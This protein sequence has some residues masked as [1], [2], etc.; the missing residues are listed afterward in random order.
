MKKAAFFDVDHTLCRD[1][2]AYLFLKRA[3]K[4]KL[5]PLRF[6]FYMP[7][8][9]FKYR[10]GDLYPEDLLRIFPGVAG[11]KK[12]IIDGIARAAF[13]EEVK[14]ALF[15]SILQEVEKQKAAGA[16]IILATSSFKSLIDPL[17]EY[18]QADDI[19]SSQLEFIDG[20]TTGALVGLPAF[21]EEKC[22]LVRIYIKENTFDFKNCSFYT[23]SWHDLPLLDLV[24][25][26]IAVNPDHR[27]A[28][29]AKKKNWTIIKAKIS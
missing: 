8:V 1:N 9:Y 6:I 11:V 2:T 7:Y 21:G 5:L 3:I 23:D 16:K 29:E 14:T 20:K 27:L 15:P 22:R 13:E 17:A 18:I 28:R 24:G 12:E 10:F 25:T 4:K 26:A 19:V